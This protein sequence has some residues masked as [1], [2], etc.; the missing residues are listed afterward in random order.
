MHW[1]RQWQPTPVFLPGASQG[2]GS[3][4]GCRL[5]GRTV[6]PDWSD[7][8]AAKCKTERQSW[9]L[10][11]EQEKI[12]FWHQ[13]FCS[14]LSFSYTYTEP[15]SHFPGV[16]PSFYMTFSV[17]SSC[18]TFPSYIPLIGFKRVHIMYQLFVIACLAVL[19]PLSM[20]N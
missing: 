2:R 6:G 4:V 14:K 10:H 17:A 7:S 3:L 19:I 5:R 15:S 11:K 16:F 9:K 8:A 12:Y 1:R 13:K 18:C 20:I